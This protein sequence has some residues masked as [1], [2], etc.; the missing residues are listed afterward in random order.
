MT[1]KEQLGPEA[2]AAL[3]TQ[4]RKVERAVT[5]V[6]SH[7]GEV[8]FHRVEGNLAGVK[9][10]DSQGT[11]Y[12]VLQRDDE[13][14][15]VTKKPEGRDE[16]TLDDFSGVNKAVGYFLYVWCNEVGL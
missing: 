14:W 16:K 11:E 6:C 8:A 7:K 5:G 2:R 10:T 12:K 15:I 9:A 13:R 4:V 3:D 1:T